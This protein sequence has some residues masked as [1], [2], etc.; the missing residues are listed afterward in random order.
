MGCVPSSASTADLVAGMFSPNLL[1]SV[2]LVSRYVAMIASVIKIKPRRNAPAHNASAAPTN[3]VVLSNSS[4]MVSHL[5]SS[6]SLL[7]FGHG[8]Y[9]V[10]GHVAMIVFNLSAI[11]CSMAGVALTWN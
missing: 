5:S 6:I 2:V 11:A 9:D 1:C 10:I 8:R 4:A 7:L 3:L